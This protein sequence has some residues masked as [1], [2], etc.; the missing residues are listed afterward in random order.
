MHVM[1]AWDIAASGPREVEIRDQLREVIQ[2]YSWA[3]PLGAVYVVK[4]TDAE[5]RE[6]SIEKLTM[7]AKNIDEKVNF[8][9]SPPMEGGRYNGW[10]PKEMWEKINQRVKT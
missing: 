6:R 4:V 1:L 8:L 3:R 9:I 10:L 5:D 7:T 2:G